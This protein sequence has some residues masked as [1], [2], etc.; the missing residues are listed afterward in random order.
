ML[1]RGGR[2]IGPGQRYD[3]WLHKIGDVTQISADSV[4]AAETFETRY[5]IFRTTAYS[6]PFWLG[7]AA[8]LVVIAF[9]SVD[10]GGGRTCFPQDICFRP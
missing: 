9:E 8:V 5:S 2:L 6:A 7:A 4:T 3:L 1:L 10:L